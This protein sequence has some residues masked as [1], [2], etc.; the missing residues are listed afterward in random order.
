MN[1]A[2]YD[3]S[4]NLGGAPSFPLVSYGYPWLN[5]FIKKGTGL[6]LDLDQVATVSRKAEQKLTDL[7]DVAKEAAAAN[8]RSRILW[9]DLPLTKG[10]RRS[11]EDVALLAKD[12]DAQS[13]LVFLDNTGFG[14]PLDEE[15]RAELPRI[16]GALLLLE[17]RIIAIL[18]PSNIP[19]V[20]RFK[21]LTRSEGEHPSDWELER[22]SRVF[23]LTL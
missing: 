1:E 18:E 23:D 9:H 7:F 11:I 4:T 10:M 15:V 19:P 6:D 12:V 21:L 5:E 3:V 22:A 17:G 13:L 20:D 8:G 16:M 2:Q 14:G